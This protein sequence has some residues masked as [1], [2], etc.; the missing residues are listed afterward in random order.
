MQIYYLPVNL[1]LF[2]F[3]RMY[4]FIIIGGGLAGS[5]LALRLIKEGAQVMF[6]DNFSANISSHVAAGIFNPITGKRTALTWK[7]KELF[8]EL[9]QYYT[10]LETELNQQFYYPLPFN[11]LFESI[12]EQ[13]EWLSKNNNDEMNAFIGAQI[14]HLN[15]NLVHNPFGSLLL[16][17]AGRIDTKSYLNA[18]HL[19]M[20]AKNIS[21]NGNINF[22]QITIDKEFVLVG[23]HKC[24]HLVFCDGANALNNPYFNYLPH[25]PVHGELIEIEMDDFYTDRIINKGIYIIPTYNNRYLVGATYNWDINTP[26]ITNEGKSELELKLQMLIKKTYKVIN[27]QAGL[28]PS[29]KDRRPFIGLHPIYKNLAYFGGFGS[30]GVSLIPYFS[31]LFV[32]HLLH[33]SPLPKE[34][35]LSRVPYN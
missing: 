17:H 31:K 27:H 22:N 10:R 18:V 13:N 5:T 11:K 12:Y 6:A 15:P 9:H 35:D 2:K 8:L 29:T 34:V 26:I 16:N 4:D 21:L 20:K 25:K 23:N 30:K 19:W 14:E 1:L 7:A 28:R 32:N 3:A 24:R 33:E